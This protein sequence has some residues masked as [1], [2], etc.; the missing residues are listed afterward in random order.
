MTKFSESIRLDQRK[1][2]GQIIFD[3][4]DNLGIKITSWFE[5]FYEVKVERNWLLYTY[6]WEGGDFI[7]IFIL[8]IHDV[9]NVFYFHR[10]MPYVYS[11]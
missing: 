5:L 7:E 11:F 1:N 3:K 8:R 10:N 4:A 2:D 6:L 9:T